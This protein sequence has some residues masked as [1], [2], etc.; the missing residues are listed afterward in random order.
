M[1]LVQC[2]CAGLRQ[3][4]APAKTGSNRQYCYFRRNLSAQVQS[5]A[6]A[7]PVASG[8]SL[9]SDMTSPARVFNVMSASGATDAVSGRADTASVVYFR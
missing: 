7:A 6:D 2:S 9:F 4:C 1:R 5:C 8:T 3:V